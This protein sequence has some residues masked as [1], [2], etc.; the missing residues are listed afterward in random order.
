[1]CKKLPVR[2]R[3]SIYMIPLDE[4]IYL[5]NELRKIRMHTTD[6]QGEYCFYGTFREISEELDHRFIGGSRTYILN[7]QHIRALVDEGGQYEVVMSNGHQLDFCKNSFLR[8]RQAYE[9]WIREE[10]EEGQ[11][12]RV[13]QTGA[14]P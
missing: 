2:I 7:A 11:K 1:M 6:E 14:T 8:I 10:Q 4:I 13:R 3:R 12:H 9:M 5:E